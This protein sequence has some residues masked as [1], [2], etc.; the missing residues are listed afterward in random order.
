MSY[1]QKYRKISTNATALLTL[2]YSHTITQA[3]CIESQLQSGTK[4]GKLTITLM[5]KGNSMVTE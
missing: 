4:S 5:K 1:T 2:K 3:Y